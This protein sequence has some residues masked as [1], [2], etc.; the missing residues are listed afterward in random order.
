MTSGRRVLFVDGVAGASGDMILGAL[1]DLGVPLARI[2]RAVESLPLD[3][4]TLR[5]DR[6][7]FE[8]E[9]TA[10][11]SRHNPR[12]RVYELGVSYTGRTYQEGKKINWKD[13]V[14]ALYC[15]LRYNLFR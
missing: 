7:G 15:I 14:W 3:G 10:K 8:P 4:F 2:R 5:E 11:I 6:F 1:V 9:F 13:G 12:L